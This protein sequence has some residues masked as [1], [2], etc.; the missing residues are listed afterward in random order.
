MDWVIYVQNL[1][2]KDPLANA[3]SGF[4]TASQTAS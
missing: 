4:L 1:V 2:A 3:L